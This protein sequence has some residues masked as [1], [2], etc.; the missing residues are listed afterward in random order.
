MQQRGRLQHDGR[1]Q[2]PCP[3]NEKRTHTRD[4][5]IRSAQVGRSLAPAIQDEQ[6]LP[7]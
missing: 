3:A 4:E 6:L 2:K 5:T 7:D 1:T